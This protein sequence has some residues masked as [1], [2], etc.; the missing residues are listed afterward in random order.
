MASAAHSLQ[1]MPMPMLLTITASDMEPIWIDFASKRFTSTGDV[2]ALPAVPHDVSIYAQPIEPGARPYPWAPWAPMVKVLWSVG[3][4]AFDGV[5][6]SWMRP[7]DRYRLTGWPDLT[8]LPHTVD[9]TRV[10]AALGEGFLDANEV[11]LVTGVEVSAAQRVLNSLSL[12]GQVTAQRG[13]LAPPV[14]L[15]RQVARR[16]HVVLVVGPM[17]AGKTTA[18]STLSDIA[19]VRTEAVNTERDVVDKPTTTVALDYG[20]T[21][22]GPS[23]KVRLYGL[24]GQRRFNFMWRVLKDRAVGLLVLV[25]GDAPNPVADLIEYLGEFSDVVD[26]GVGVVVAITRSES[27]SAPPLDAYQAALALRYTARR[28]PV[29]RVDPR[30]RH[31]MYSVLTA[32]TAGIEARALLSA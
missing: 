5:P 16:S 20:E 21:M 23:G 24:P 14:D 19:T 15:G 31:Q 18:I 11:G 1:Q 29:L 7:D 32:L 2:D 25:N 22:L 26:R 9:E 3:R 27:P 6:A 28:I 4:Q 13:H 10:I 8:G 17:G 12:L 30:D